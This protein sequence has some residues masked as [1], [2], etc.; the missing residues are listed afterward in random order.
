MPWMSRQQSYPKGMEGEEACIEDHE[1]DNS[2]PESLLFV[3]SPCVG[4]VAKVQMMSTWHRVTVSKGKKKARLVSRLL[5]VPRFSELVRLRHE[6]FMFCV[7]F[8]EIKKLTGLTASS[9]TNQMVVQATAA[10]CFLWM[11]KNFIM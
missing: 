3:A 4:P 1:E 9:D 2:K 6:D 10:L 5:I 11:W 8:E 7:P